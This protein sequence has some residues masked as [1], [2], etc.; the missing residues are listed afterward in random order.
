MK[1]ELFC[2]SALVGLMC[3]SLLVSCSNPFLPAD[4]LSGNGLCAKVVSYKVYPEEMSHMNPNSCCEIHFNRKGFVLETVFLAPDGTP[5]SREKYSYGRRNHIDVIDLFDTDGYNSGWY[6]YSYDGDFIS[7]C[8]LYGMNSQVL[9]KWENT[10]DGREVVRC[11]TYQED[12]LS[13]DASSVYDGNTRV[14]TVLDGQGQWAGTTT[15]EY[16]DLRNKLPLRIDCTFPEA[17]PLHIEIDYNDHG[18]P[19]RSLNVFLDARNGF[20]QPVDA[21]PGEVLYEYEYDSRGNWSRRYEFFVKKSGE[22]VSGEVLK[23]ELVY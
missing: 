21:P 18:L 8:T 19:C 1:F 6:S 17:E 14:E 5:A 7:V 9:L 12:I 2:Q 20:Y 4:D 22:K 10:N 15:C 11:R 3:C 16:Y 23:R 13:S